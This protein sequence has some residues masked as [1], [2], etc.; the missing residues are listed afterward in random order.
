MACVT[1]RAAQ[2]FSSCPML[3]ENGSTVY[4]DGAL[5]CQISYLSASLQFVKALKKF[6]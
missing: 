4:L 5:I 3:M 1:F 6:K 2:S